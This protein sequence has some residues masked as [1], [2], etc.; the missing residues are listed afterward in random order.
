MQL[1]DT[2]HPVEQHPVV[3]D[4]QQRTLEVVEH[5]VELGAGIGVEVVGRLV[6]QQHIGPLQQFGGQAERDHLTAAQ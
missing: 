4:Q 3:A 1:G 5:V 2:L 6:E